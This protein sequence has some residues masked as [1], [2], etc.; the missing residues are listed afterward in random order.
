M[1]LVSC[2]PS[3]SET[4]DTP[5]SSRSGVEQQE[6]TNKSSVLKSEDDADLQ[7]ALDLVELHYGVKEKHLQGT[8]EGLVAARREVNKVLADL[9]RKK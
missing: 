9:Q 7:R 8:D 5:D 2:R 1:A 4:S 6:A 3:N